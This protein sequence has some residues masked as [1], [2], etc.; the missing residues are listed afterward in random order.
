VIGSSNEL[1]IGSRKRCYGRKLALFTLASQQR[2]RV[3]FSAC[4]LVC[5]A[6][7]FSLGQGENCGSSILLSG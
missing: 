7:R 6:A 3:T 4:V 2:V 1:L 5:S